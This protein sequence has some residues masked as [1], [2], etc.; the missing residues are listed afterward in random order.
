MLRNSEAFD[1]VGGTLAATALY[2]WLIWLHV[3]IQSTTRAY[4]VRT[5][6]RQA[7]R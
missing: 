1:A 7:A 4:R 2:A 3:Q 6:T 5:M